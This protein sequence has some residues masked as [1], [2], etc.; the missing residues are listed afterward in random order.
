MIDTERR[1]TP[2]GRLTWIALFVGL[3]LSG[4]PAE[5]VQLTLTWVDN[6]ITEGGY[7]IERCAG[8]PSCPPTVQ[9]D[10]VGANIITYVDLAVAA[11]TTYCYRVRAFDGLVFSGYSNTA[12]GTPVQLF[13]LVVAKA[14]TGS[15]TV[16]SNPAGI[17]CG[18]TCS[19]AYNGGTVVT[20]SAVPDA[21]SVFTGWSGGGC[22]GTGTCT[23]TVTAATTVTATFTLQSFIF[24]VSRAGNGGG[25]VSSLPVGISCGPT[26]SASYSSGTVVTL[27]A[28]PA[29]GSV[30][31]GWSG[32]GC[33]GTGTCTVTVVAAVNVTATFTLIPGAPTNLIIISLVGSG[34]GTVTSRP[35]G[36]VCGTQC[37]A[38]F[39]PGTVVTLTER[40]GRRSRFDGWG[41]ACRGDDSR[42]RVAVPGPALGPLRVSA[43]FG[44]RHRRGE[45]D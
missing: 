37:E 7:A 35:P 22:A 16:T 24:S 17:T 41:G 4:S 19:A 2:M 30:F 33:A 23:V 15:G 45:E 21:G 5:S 27:T 12:C 3:V 14:G 6:A 29:A 31:T 10:I 42:C 8:A 1:R 44:E 28:A 26:C 38:A 25:F 40:A 18:S 20:L 9:L 13:A 34:T 39:P 11:G 43:G 36:L 32:G